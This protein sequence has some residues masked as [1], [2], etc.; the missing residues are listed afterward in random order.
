MNN[1][2][3]YF[4]SDLSN[5]EI[6]IAQEE[7]HHLVHVVR[8]R[9]GEEI[10]L[11]DGKGTVVIA[12]MQNVSLKNCMAV[13]NSRKQFNPAAFKLH[14]AFAPTKNSDRTEWMLEK[15][16]EMGVS[17]FT[18][19]RC[20]HSERKEIN[21]D[22]LRKI[23]VAA[24]KQSKR[25]WFPIL[26]P[27]TAFSD[28]IGKQTHNC[29]LAHCNTEYNRSGWI[30]LTAAGYPCTVMIGPEG[31]FSPEEIEAASAMGISGLNL[32]N[33]RLRTETAAMAVCLPLLMHDEE[34]VK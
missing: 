19:I 14:L 1:K 24:A 7:A 27:V 28:F 31:D 22:R 4:S 29:F 5:D 33:R 26:N 20:K 30:E 18:P 13:V 32:G 12:A 11:T 6:L 17:E 3:W 2:Q 10:V 34:E 16:T 8:I 9:A 15:A 23:I 21:E 25:A